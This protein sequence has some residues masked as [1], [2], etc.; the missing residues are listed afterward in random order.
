MMVEDRLADHKNC[1]ELLPLRSNLKPAMKEI[2]QESRKV[3]HARKNVGQLLLRYN[4][5]V[6]LPYV[7]VVIQRHYLSDW[8][9]AEADFKGLKNKK[10]VHCIGIIH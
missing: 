4:D 6:R 10:D 5:F 2:S 9:A 3:E 1:E 7:T 8:N